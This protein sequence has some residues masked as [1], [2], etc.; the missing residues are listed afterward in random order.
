MG[1]VLTC[2]RKAKDQKEKEEETNSL[3]IAEP[4][5]GFGGIWNLS[6]KMKPFPFRWR[7]LECDSIMV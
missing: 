6:N 2:M 4:R 7:Q 5:T 1:I 3:Q